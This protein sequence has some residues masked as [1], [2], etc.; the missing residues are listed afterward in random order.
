M[1]FKNWKIGN[2]SSNPP[3][4]DA[5]THGENQGC[6]FLSMTLAYKAAFQTS[7]SQ[8]PLGQPCVDQ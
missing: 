3:R 7:L 5:E 4:R 6:A 8:I 1:I 2:C